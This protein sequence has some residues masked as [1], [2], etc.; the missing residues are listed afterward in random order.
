MFLKKCIFENVT[1]KN[2]KFKEA[3]LGSNYVQA[4]VLQRLQKEI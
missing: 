1:Q 3:P 2:Q 4:S